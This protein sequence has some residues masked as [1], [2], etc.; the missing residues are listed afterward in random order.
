MAPWGSIRV[1]L[2]KQKKKK[3]KEEVATLAALSFWVCTGG[4]V[5]E[6]P[7][8]IGNVAPFHSCYELLEVPSARLQ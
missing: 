8:G 3:K 1:R 2:G 4:G 5:L 6:S 7:S